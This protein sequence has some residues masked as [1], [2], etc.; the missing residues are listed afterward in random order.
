MEVFMT[1]LTLL[2]NLPLGEGFGFNGNILETNIIN[3]TVVIG[4]VVSF[5]GD[6]LR[7]LLENRRQIILNNLREADLRAAEAQEKLTKAKTQLEL[8]QKKAVE[9]R[10]QGKITAEQEKKQ[11]IRQAEAD[12]ARLE[13]IKQ[14]TLQLQQQK[15]ISQVSQQVVSLA[16]SQVREKL[17]GR[18][19]ATFHSSVINFNIVLF[20]NYKT[21]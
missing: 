14:E 16:L 19:D 21:R 2:N 13:E 12:I 6:A 9:I 8:A 1:N 7:A 11:C 20:T 3:L 17:N 4:V 5:G 18:L 15:A 10:E